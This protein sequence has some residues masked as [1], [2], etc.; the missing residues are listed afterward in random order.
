[1][2]GALNGQEVQS[3][4]TG[5]ETSNLIVDGPWLPEGLQGKVHELTRA[6]QET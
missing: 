4:V 1:V 6:N 5:N 2:S 3:L